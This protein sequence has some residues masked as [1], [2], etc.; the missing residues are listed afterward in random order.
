MIYIVKI[1]FSIVRETIVEFGTHLYNDLRKE[2]LKSE[3]TFKMLETLQYKK[4]IGSRCTIDVTC[5]N[6]GT[7]Q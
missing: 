5:E 3:N 4:V 2:S 1:W 7:K 6:W